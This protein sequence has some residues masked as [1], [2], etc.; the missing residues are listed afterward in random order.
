[1]IRL[2]KLL[3]CIVLAGVIFGGSVSLAQRGSSSAQ[4]PRQQAS[5]HIWPLFVAF[6]LLGLGC[7]PVFKNSKRELER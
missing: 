6:I 5:T 4:P 2:R 1:M 7:A 3:I